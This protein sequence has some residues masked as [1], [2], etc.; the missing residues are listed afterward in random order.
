M[1]FTL[2]DGSTFAGRYQIVQTIATGGMGT[3]YEAVHIET[4]RRCAI[5]AMLPHIVQSPD[6]R[7]RFKLETR[8]SAQ[9]ES[10]FIVDVFDAGVD[11]PT[12]LPFLVMELLRGEELDVVLGRAGHLSPTE[13]VTYLHQ[14][15]LALDKTH[16][17]SI[18]HRDLKPE[19][20]FLT[21]R[22]DGSPRIKVLDFGIAKIM[23]DGST[24]AA[25]TRNFG[26]PFYMSP[27]QYMG[28]GTIGPPS[29]IYAL[30]MLAYHFLAG[31]AYWA[32][33]LRANSNMYAFVT[34][35][36]MGPK[37]AASV[38]AA[39]LGV[40]LP[41]AFDR[42]FATA[43]APVPTDRFPSAT[44]ATQALAQVFGIPTL[45]GGATIAG[46]ITQTHAPVP[47]S[48]KSMGSHVL[49]AA[50]LA[51]PLIIGAAIHIVRSRSMS[52]SSAAQAPP[53]PSA[54][55][56]ALPAASVAAT[57]MPAAAPVPPS[58]ASVQQPPAASASEP[59]AS[60]R[61]ATSRKKPGKAP[62]P[63]TASTTK[64]GPIYSQD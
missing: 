7:E 54:E 12:G 6:L 60:A 2:Q 16:A 38:R 50:L 52:D 36:V 27:E 63:S 57:V 43:T 37:D 34:T 35:A 21:K 17:A 47:Q 61:S 15:A 48:R 30:G 4:G 59:A 13:A 40:T 19:N 22:D 51:L 56:A 44:M 28:E 1:S 64:A 9:I 18:V 24:E 62:P 46:G 25:V 41:P 8:V 49:L 32:P 33:E 42:W 3:V 29:D 53:P 55:A 10:E 39:R 23:A 14:T 11:E 31:E 58:S 5:K 26:T 20:L 45:A